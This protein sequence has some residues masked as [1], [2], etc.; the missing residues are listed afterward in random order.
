LIKET[1]PPVRPASS[2]VEKPNPGKNLQASHPSVT[3]TLNAAIT[4]ITRAPSIEAKAPQ[5]PSYRS[6][7]YNTNV[8]PWGSPAIAQHHLSLATKH[9]KA[10]NQE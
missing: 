10:K 2:A 1:K 5:P 3:P 7:I 8:R 9:N 4:T 6:K